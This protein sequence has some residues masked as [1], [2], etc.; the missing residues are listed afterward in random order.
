MKLAKLSSNISCCISTTFK[1]SKLK[2]D[3]PEP[4]LASTWRGS[5]SK[6]SQK[7]NQRRP[8]EKN[9]QISCLG[10]FSNEI[11]DI[12][13]LSRNE[14]LVDR[15]NCQQALNRGSLHLKM[16]V[17]C[18]DLRSKRAKR[19]KIWIQVMGNWIFFVLER[20]FLLDCSWKIGPCLQTIQKHH[21]LLVVFSFTRRTSFNESVPDVDFIFSTFICS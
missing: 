4:S 18:L 9:I 13:W 20:F 3:E 11:F 19:S 5:R 6:K 2:S 8:I 7:L 15:Q 21:F 10:F 14:R 17:F 16:P 1:S 12:K